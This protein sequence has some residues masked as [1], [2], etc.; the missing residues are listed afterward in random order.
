MELHEYARLDGVAIAG[1]VRA[2]EVTAAEVERVA[3][4]AVEVANQRVNGLAGPP[5]RVPGDPRG[6]FSGVPFLVKDVPMAAGV[7]FGVGSRAVPSFVVAEYDTEVMA[8]FRRAGLLTLGRTTMPELGLS[9]ATEPR[10]HGP[11]RNPYDPSRGAGGS[12][13]G[14]AALVAAGAVPIAH[15]NDGAGSIRVPASCCGLVGLKPSAGRLPGP[16]HLGEFALTRTVRDTA[17]LFEAVYGPVLP[18]GDGRP[19]RLRAG[20]TTVAWSG[21][22]VHPE[23]AAVTERAGKLLERLGLRVEP[24]APRLDWDDVRA[25]MHGELAANVAPMLAAPRSPD[26]AKLEAVTRAVIAEVRAMSALDL[27]SAAAAGERAARGVW[28][29]FAEYDLL[30]TPTLAQLPAEHGT[31]DY[32]DPRYTVDGWLDAMLA[33]GPFT[34]VFNLAG[35]PAISLPL[36]RSTTRLPIGV[37]VV[38]AHGREDRLLAVAAT[39]EGDFADLNPRETH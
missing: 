27:L 1:L 35:Q 38:A 29:F 10:R 19:E 37:Q 12:S 21:V 2:G 25:A 28:E 31:L 6:P 11:A 4:V 32:D 14:A 22:A 3:L 7:P 36:G 24:V 34:T 33:Y 30:V 17:R 13:G 15:A 39:L 18:G 23:V 8:R 9:F 16:A 20:I 26:P 5:V